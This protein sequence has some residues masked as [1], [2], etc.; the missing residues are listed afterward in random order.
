MK[1]DKI[2]LS[3]Y[4]SNKNKLLEIM[5]SGLKDRY[6]NECG[7]FYNGNVNLIM[8]TDDTKLSKRIYTVITPLSHVIIRKRSNEYTLESYRICYQGIYLDQN[9]LEN[10]YFLYNYYFDNYKILK[11]YSDESNLYKI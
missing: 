10:S 3:S 8:R 4:C 7:L 11:D 6:K 5:Q 9:T 1:S 2:G